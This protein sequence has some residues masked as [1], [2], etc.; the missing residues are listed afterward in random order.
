M[1]RFNL[2]LTRRIF[3]FFTFYLCFL[4]LNMA[5]NTIK[6]KLEKL[7]KAPKTSILKGNITIIPSYN[8]FV[9]DTDT[10]KFRTT[11][12]NI[13]IQPSFSYARMRAKG[14]FFQAS[15]TGF[16]YA[17]R[18]DLQESINPT[19]GAVFPAR[20]A[21]TTVFNISTLLEW[22]IPI[23][24][25]PERK[26]NFFVGW[27]VGEYFSHNNLKPYTS[28]SFPSKTTEF[29]LNFSLVP[30]WQ[31]TISEK[32]FID[33][34]LPYAF[35]TTL[36]EHRFYNNPALPTFAKRSNNYDLIWTPKNIRLRVG[37]AVR[38]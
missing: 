9:L 30:S 10:S 38:I 24:Y 3:L 8:R 7:P 16:R 27:G 2:F 14:A 31:Y 5:Q 22:G 4:T 29:N 15:L 36:W 20:G 37:L 25:N 17:K 33:I 6:N 35:A 21:K 12:S 26:S 18:D 34:A 19:S 23:A 1:K 32:C 11:E 13:Y 28:A